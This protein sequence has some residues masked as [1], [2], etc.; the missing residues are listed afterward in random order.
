MTKTNS[1]SLTVRLDV[2]KIKN[3]TVRLFCDSELI[4]SATTE[5]HELGFDYTVTVAGMKACANYTVTVTGLK[6]C[7]DYTVTRAATTG[8]GQGGQ[9]N[10]TTQIPGNLI[11]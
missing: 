5:E 11:F 7:V 9:T 8:A 3:Y 4:N 6:A 1:S 2:P 10:T